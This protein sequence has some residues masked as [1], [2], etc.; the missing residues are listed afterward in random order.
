GQ[1]VDGEVTFADPHWTIAAD[2]GKQHQV[3]GPREFRHTLSTLVNGLVARGFVLLGLWEGPPGG[4]MNAKPGTWEHFI[5]VVPPW[6]TFW[7]R[8]RPEVFGEPYG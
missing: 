5:A 8:L 2:D 6:L 7:A 4:D 1:Y 3:V